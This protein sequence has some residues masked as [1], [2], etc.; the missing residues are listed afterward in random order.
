[1]LLRIIL[2]VGGGLLLFAGIL[3]DEFI[4]MVLGSVIG[5]TGWCLSY[6]TEVKRREQAII[7]GVSSKLG[8]PSKNSILLERN[9]KSCGKIIPAGYSGCPNC[10]YVEPPIDLSSL[11]IVKKNNDL[12]ISCPHCKTKI[13]LNM[14]FDEFTEI[15]CSRCGKTIKK[16]DAVFE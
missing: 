12:N 1:M 9:C 10:G 16:K 14:T 15:N 7:N 3:N 5:I 8:S 2:S 4:L 11:E 13:S 6:I